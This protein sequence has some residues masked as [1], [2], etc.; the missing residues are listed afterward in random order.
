M[1]AGLCACSWPEVGRSVHEVLLL[2]A[3]LHLG[4]SS[5][6]QR[7]PRRENMG[8]FSAQVAAGGTALEQ[9]RC[10]LKQFGSF[11]ALQSSA[12]LSHRFSWCRRGRQVTR[13]PGG[14]LMQ[15][16]W[17]PRVAAVAPWWCVGVLRSR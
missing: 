1:C 4:V 3:C 16:W 17:W 15:G 10:V 8:C 12:S 9:E 11:S 13:T 14:L 6:G 2:P 5:F 7:H